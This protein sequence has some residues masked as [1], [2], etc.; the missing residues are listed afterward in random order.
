MILKYELEQFINDIESKLPQ[1]EGKAYDNAKDKI[2]I[3]NRVNIEFMSYED[4]MRKLAKDNSKANIRS[5]K[6]ERELEDLKK[7]VKHLKDNING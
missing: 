6:L 3:L 2:A 7:E 1:L 4:L 5:L